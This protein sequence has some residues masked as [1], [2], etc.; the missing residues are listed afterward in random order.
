MDTSSSDSTAKSVDVTV[1]SDLNCAWCWIGLRKLKLAA[2]EANV[3]PSIEFKAFLV[4]PHIPDE[5]TPKGGLPSA[6]V[7]KQLQEAAL[8]VGINLTGLCN[9][10]PSTKLFHA[11]IRMLQDDPDVNS[12]EVVNFYEAA[13]EGYHTNGIFPDKEGLLLA[14]RRIGSDELFQKVRALYD[15]DFKLLQLKDE[16]YDEAMECLRNGILGVPHFKFDKQKTFSGAQPLEMF[17][18]FHETYAS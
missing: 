2:Q 14:A 13:F 9:R 12:G 1:T 18:L 7:P 17:T 6:R 10:T 4:N 11:T 5:G 8:K 15:D 3:E 16:A